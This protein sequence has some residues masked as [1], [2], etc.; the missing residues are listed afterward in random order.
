MAEEQ[1]RMNE[2]I[3]EYIWM[4]R[5]KGIG[6]KNEIIE[7]SDVDP[8]CINPSQPIYVIRQIQITQSSPSKIHPNHIHVRRGQRVAGVHPKH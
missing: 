1:W 7:W 3:F 6:W 2:W 4:I 5:I 8:C